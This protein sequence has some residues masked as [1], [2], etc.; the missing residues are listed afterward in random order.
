M[1]EIIKH[2]IVKWPNGHMVGISVDCVVLQIFA[3]NVYRK[4]MKIS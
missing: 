3:K 1:T 2:C 4:V